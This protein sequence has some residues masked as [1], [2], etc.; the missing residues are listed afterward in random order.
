M[1]SEKRISRFPDDQFFITHLSNCAETLTK[2]MAAF[3][4]TEKISLR[5]S[6]CGDLRVVLHCSVT[7]CQIRCHQ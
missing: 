7:I 2:T 6:F 5:S 1:K 4:H 3:G